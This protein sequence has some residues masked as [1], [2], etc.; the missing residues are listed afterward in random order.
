GATMQT[1]RAA[2]GTANL[3]LHDTSLSA[4]F[5]A[6]LVQRT[7]EVGSL[8]APGGAAFTLA[9]VSS[10]KASFGVPDVMVVKLKTGAKLNLFTEAL[11]DYR[12]EGM[13]TNIAAVADSS[14]RLFQVQ[15]SVANPQGRLKPGM[16]ATLALGNAVKPDPRP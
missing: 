7:V 6:A 10:V 5:P 16:I 12:F 13:I 9:D 3:G 8:V 14:T 15:V 11:P 1:A 4:P 2:L